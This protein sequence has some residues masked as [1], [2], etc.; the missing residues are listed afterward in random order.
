MLRALFRV[1]L[2]G[3]AALLVLVAA[4]SVYLLYR[5]GHFPALRKAVEDATIVGSV[6]AAY[7]LHRDL[8]QR[9]I[10]VEADAGRV[11]LSGKVATEKE[12]AEAEELALGVDGVVAVENGL[13]VQPGLS[14]A[15]GD[16]RSLGEQLDD[17]AL[18][19]KIKT[20]LR[21]D[22]ET[23]KLDL[24]VEVR[25]GVVHLGGRVPDDELRL[26]A[27]ERVKAVSGVEKLEETIEVEE[28]SGPGADSESPQ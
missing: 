28:R 16:P 12:S 6:K 14:T 22:K 9:T 20:A 5:G 23:K 7:A 2:R 26:R 19:A 1:F 25:E 18:L 27:I 8:A 3:V 11:A 15:A 21:L 13:E 4:V 10:R 17:V 24:E